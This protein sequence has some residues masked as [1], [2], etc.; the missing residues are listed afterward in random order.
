MELEKSWLVLD[1]IEFEPIET[2]WL[3]KQRKIPRKMW[4]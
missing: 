1:D 3:W 4:H 2:G